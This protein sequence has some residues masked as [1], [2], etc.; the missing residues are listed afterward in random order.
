MAI[1]PAAYGTILVPIDFSKTSE[2]A[3][4]VARSLA[5]SAGPARLVLVHACF[6]PVEV[7][8]LI[9][10]A[11]AQRVEVEREARESL[12]QL[13]ERTERGGIACEVAIVW[14]RPEHVILTAAADREADLIVIG[15]HGR[16]GL[17]HV[18]LGS[19][20]ERVV[21]E[22]ECPVLTVKPG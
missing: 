3:F 6:V 16:T 10:S 5:T 22:A 20:A 13:R 15:T 9:G 12:D 8:A 18:V 17:A 21:R 4:D 14:G 2:R 7:E 1:E 11:A 19:V